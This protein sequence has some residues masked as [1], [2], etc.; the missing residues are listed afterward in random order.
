MSLLGDVSVYI[1]YAERNTTYGE[2]NF[3]EAICSD[4]NIVETFYP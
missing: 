1:H 2:H 4:H 3:I